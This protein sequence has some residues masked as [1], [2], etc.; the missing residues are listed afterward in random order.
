MNITLL[1]TQ[2]IDQF[3]LHFRDGFDKALRKTGGD[4][5]VGDLWVEARS[6]RGFVFVAYD[7]ERIAGA[8]VWRF[9]TWTSGQIFRCLALYGRGMKGW[10][11]DMRTAVKLA[12]GDAELAAEGRRG[13]PAP[14]PNVKIIRVLYRD[15]NP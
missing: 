10:I 13:W 7:G 9:E 2:Q 5:A 1:P 11:Y 14:F 12:A 6:G 8:S 3:W 4:M 15:T